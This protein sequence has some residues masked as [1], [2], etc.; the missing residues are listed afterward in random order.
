MTLGFHIYDNLFDS[1]ITYETLLDLLFGRNIPNY[2]CDEENVLSIIGGLT[3]EDSIEMAIILS[4][5]KIPHFI[6][7]SFEATLN[8]KKYF[9]FM[10]WMAPEENTYHTGLVQLLSY[11]KWT[12]IGLLLSDDD[13]GENF[14]QRLIPLLSKNSICVAFLQKDRENNYKVKNLAGEPIPGFIQRLAS[15]D[16]SVIIVSMDSRLLNILINFFERYEKYR[17]VDIKKVWILPPQWYPSI[18][19]KRKFIGNN[20]LEGA[21]SF[22]VHTKP[23]PGFQDFLKNLNSD[24][25]LMEFICLFWH[26]VILQCKSCRGQ[27]LVD[28][29]AHF[30]EMTMSG[31]SY[32][33]YNAVYAVAH[34]LHAISFS[35]RGFIRDKW[36]LE[37]SNVHPWQVI[38][39][40]KCL[41]M[42]DYDVY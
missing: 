21:F 34:A 9:P 24:K 27:K 17:K 5:Y 18:T 40:S 12:W 15:T 39:F 37:D 13:N 35:R 28:L 14:A 23:V 7:G 20:L 8:D 41:S 3:V 32:S 19:F 22:T 11:F 2:R 4:I 1:M 29:P 42:N 10:Y 38:H 33:I 31:E 30:F 6:Y 25:A 26:C 16:A 36:K